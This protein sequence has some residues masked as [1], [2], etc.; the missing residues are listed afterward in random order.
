MGIKIVMVLAIVAL[1]G[2][3]MPMMTESALSCG[4]VTSS[5]GPCLNYLKNGGALRN[6]CCAGIKR[7][8]GMAQT[9]PDRRTASSSDQQSRSDDEVS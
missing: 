6:G 7:L 3:T 1:V 4:Q 9:A 5:L 8:V 2:A